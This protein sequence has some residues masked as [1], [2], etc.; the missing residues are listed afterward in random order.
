MKMLVIT[1]E[2][3]AEGEIEAVNAMFAAG[4]ELLHLR[5]PSYSE[6]EYRKYIAAIKAQ[7]RSRMVIHGFYHLFGELGLNGIHLNEAARKDTDIWLQLK[8]VSPSVISTSFHSWQEI[9]ENVIPFRYVFISPVFDSISKTGYKAGIALD[10]ANATKEELNR[11]K[12]YCPEI[13]GLGGVGA[14]E[15]KILFQNGFDGGALLGSIWKSGQP[16]ARFMEIKEK[17]N[18]W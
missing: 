14:E 17:V 1:P 12:G 3:N 10:R 2:Q 5:K 7:Y 11:S 6:Q 16:A 4:L 8:H 9:M 18:R 13:I 15:L